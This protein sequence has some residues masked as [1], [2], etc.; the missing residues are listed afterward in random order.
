MA[1]KATSPAMLVYAGAAVFLYFTGLFSFFVC[2]PLIVAYYVRGYE[3]C[4]RSALVFFVVV[5]LARVAS[6]FL[7]LSNEAQVAL[8]QGLQEGSFISPWSALLHEALYCMSVV[9]AVV[10]LL[11]SHFAWLP[12]I[13]VA[14]FVLFLNTYAQLRYAQANLSAIID[15]SPLLSTML[16]RMASGEG[17]NNIATSDAENLAAFEQVF[18]VAVL[19]TW[20]VVVCLIMLNWVIA[21]MVTRRML[22]F[23]ID[24][25]LRYVYAKVL[26][27]YSV[28]ALLLL[29]VSM[30][31]TL[32]LRGNTRTLLVHVYNFFGNV[33][34]VLL[35]CYMI[36][37]FC[38]W[39]FILSQRLMALPVQGEAVQKRQLRSDW[40]F[41]S[42]CVIMVIP[43]I[44][45]AVSALCVVMGIK[46]NIQHIKNAYAMRSSDEGNSQV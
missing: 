34:V 21:L 16:Q 29:F 39:Y 42:V 41:F 10:V 35:L 26:N 20:G 13:L 7:F 4:K 45:T 44:N 17:V 24:E 5:M 11:H 27:Y 18:A 14:T 31:V 46:K 28:K 6:T 38:A 3:V 9:V 36:Y 22:K 25:Y 43:F 15:T 12:R 37:G 1:I 19:F 40:Y 2:I 8:S 30:L 32:L 33:F 23:S